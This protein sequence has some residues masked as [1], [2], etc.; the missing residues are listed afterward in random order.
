[1]LGPGK[2]SRS[3]STSRPIVSFAGPPAGSNDPWTPPF[4]SYATI[5]HNPHEASIHRRRRHPTCP[6]F[7]PGRAGPPGT[8]GPAGQAGPAGVGIDMCRLAAGPGADC[9]RLAV[10]AGQDGA[11]GQ[12][13]GRRVGVTTPGGAGSRHR[14]LST[15]QETHR[16][17]GG[18]PHGAA[19]VRQQPGRNNRGR[20]NRGRNKAGPQQSG[21]NKGGSRRPRGKTSAPAGPSIAPLLSPG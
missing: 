12:P 18:R 6:E 19:Q 14:P 15:S 1:V 5:L 17:G 4:L 7:T 10:R 21:R 3:E 8:S 20:N 11:G 2:P 9:G 13:A 16:V